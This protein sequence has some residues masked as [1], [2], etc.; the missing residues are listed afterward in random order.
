MSLPV[1]YMDAALLG[2]MLLAALVA[3]GLFV[4][5]WV[6]R[7][8]APA[9]SDE[10]PSDTRLLLQLMSRADHALDNYV[11]SIQGHLSVL[12][13]ELPTDPQRWQV[14]RDAI[15]EAATQM[16]RHVERLRLIRMGLDETSL[17]VAPV[18]LARLIE[19][20]LIALEPAATE[21]DVTLRMEVQRLTQPV[22]GDPQMFEEI[23]ATLLDNAIKHNPPGTEVVAELTRNGDMALARISDNGKGM[24]EDLVAHIFQQGARDSG[25]GT[26]RGT[27]M[28]LYI[29]KMLAELHGGAIAVE[30]EPG[31]GSVFTVSLPLANGPVK[32]LI[33]SS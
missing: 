8:A 11:T 4:W 10:S 28:G 2:G 19:H 21:R 20:I 17:R 25:A 23:F 27:G 26:P 5:L 33:R 24:N 18:N 31:K 12:G 1:I 32:E 29:A 7:R 6:R 3:G 13:E 22:P 16:K 15:G 30:S 9:A 14:S